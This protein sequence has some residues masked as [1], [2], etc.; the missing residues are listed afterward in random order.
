M[1]GVNFFYELMSGINV[2]FNLIEMAV[3][4]IFAWVGRGKAKPGQI[5]LGGFGPKG[6]K[7]DPGERGARGQDGRDGRDGAAG[8]PGHCVDCCRSRKYQEFFGLPP[9]P[10]SPSQD[11]PR[12]RPRPR[13]LAGY[14]LRPFSS[15]LPGCHYYLWP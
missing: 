11:R 5:K 9:L 8:P 13:R 15:I 10:P 3:K 6:E 12:P 4:A 2:V 1:S 7:G 14:L